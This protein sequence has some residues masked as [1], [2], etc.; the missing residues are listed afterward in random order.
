MLQANEEIE[1]IRSAVNGDK[2]AGDKLVRAHEPMLRSIAR[3]LGRNLEFED[4]YAE[5]SFGFLRSLPRYDQNSG[6]RLN[7]YAR[8]YA[9]EAV[10]VASSKSYLVRF[11]MSDNTVAT[12]KA[13]KK[14]Q[15]EGKEV[16]PE[17][18]AE[19]T[20][21]DIAIAKENYGRIL[22]SR[23]STYAPLEAAYEIPDSR[24]NA[25]DEIERRMRLKVVEDAI[26]GLTDREKHI[27][28]TRIAANDEPLTLEELG[29]IHGVSRERIRQI[30]V[31]IL[32]KFEKE[33]KK[34]GFHSCQAA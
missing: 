9:A 7:T 4:A 5:A 19:E 25:E 27:F 30:E 3:T 21:L 24:M 15:Q 11:P 6:N 20:G 13:A 12:F 10:R 31:L 22:H 23:A 29:N 28:K 18:L 8:H 26:S 34:R 32:K 17:N 16:T 33:M 1:L 2:R 14:I